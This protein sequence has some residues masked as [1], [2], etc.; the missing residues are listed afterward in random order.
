MTYT[1]RL[2]QQD[3]PETLD[4]DIEV[5]EPVKQGFF[6]IRLLVVDKCRAKEAN[7][8]IEPGD[9]KSAGITYVHVD[10]SRITDK[11]ATYQDDWASIKVLYTDPE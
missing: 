11:D 4:F 5:K 9:G 6:Y 2:A 8:D 7:G 1:A 3:S 10:N